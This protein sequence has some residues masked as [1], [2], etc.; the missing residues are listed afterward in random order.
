MLGWFSQIAIDRG[1]PTFIYLT[2][3]GK[4]IEVTAVSQDDSY[5]FPDKV[6]LGPVVK[7]LRF[8][9]KKSWH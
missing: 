4:E 9:R 6:L 3:D 7:F 8:G 2:P 1:W 5:P